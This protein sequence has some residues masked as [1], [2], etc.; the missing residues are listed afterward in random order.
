MNLNVEE[1]KY[2]QHVLHCASSFTIA[3]GRE[4]IAPSVNHYELKDK[5]KAYEDRL[6]YG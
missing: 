5:I 4:T 2:L 6:R 3:R 1:L